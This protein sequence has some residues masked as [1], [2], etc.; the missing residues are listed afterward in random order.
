[1]LSTF[2]C[3][4]LVA[5]TSPLSDITGLIG[6]LVVCFILAWW[7]SSIFNELFGMGIETILFCYIADEEMFKVEDR[8]VEGELLSVFQKTHQAYLCVTC[9]NNC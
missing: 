8:Y 6:P 9:K 7:I 2:L 4:V 3:Y 5:Y 1:M